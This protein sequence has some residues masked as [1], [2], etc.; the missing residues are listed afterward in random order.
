MIG[1]FLI[2]FGHLPLSDTLKEICY[3]NVVVSGHTDIQI[4]SIYVFKIGV[5]KITFDKW[6]DFKTF[7]FH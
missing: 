6:S 5:L 2:Y 4:M 3:K 1:Y 7:L